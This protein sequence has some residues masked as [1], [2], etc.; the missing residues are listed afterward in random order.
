[1]SPTIFGQQIFPHLSQVLV[2]QVYF[3]IRVKPDIPTCCQWLDPRTVTKALLSRKRKSTFSVPTQKESPSPVFVFSEPFPLNT[4]SLPF[5]RPGSIDWMSMV[6]AQKKGKAVVNNP[7]KCLIWVSRFR[8]ALL[9]YSW[10]VLPSPSSLS[11]HSPAT[12]FT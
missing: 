3:L 1:M 5:C 10:I 7:C 6:A 2:I 4:F 12:S 11:L 9:L 8:L